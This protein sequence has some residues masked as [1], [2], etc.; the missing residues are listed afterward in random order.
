MNLIPV[1][2]RAFRAY[3]YRR[4]VLTVVFHSGK[5]YR[6]GWVPRRVFE[7]LQAAPSKGHYFATAIR[8]HYRGRLVAEALSR[9]TAR[10]QGRSVTTNVEAAP[11]P[12]VR[13]TPM[14]ATLPPR[15]LP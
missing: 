14:M 9:L 15:V 4:G 5:V 2:S 10:D 3:G 13:N 7:A 1:Q 6:Y 12:K 11:V 8:P